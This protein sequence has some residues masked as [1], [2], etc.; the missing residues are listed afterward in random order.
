MGVQQARCL[1]RNVHVA[2]QW[3]VAGQPRMHLEIVDR[4]FQLGLRLKLPV[5]RRTGFTFL[6]LSLGDDRLLSES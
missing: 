6:D 2:V 1:T 3:V 5:S 4:A